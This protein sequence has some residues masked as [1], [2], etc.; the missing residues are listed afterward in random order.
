MMGTITVDTRIEP[1]CCLKV[2]ADQINSSDEP[3]C[4]LRA[5]LI[6]VFST[7]SNLDFEGISEAV[8][9]SLE[10]CEK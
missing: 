9:F 5:A 10:A 3:D 7:I 2:L 4:T 8:K 6:A 1:W